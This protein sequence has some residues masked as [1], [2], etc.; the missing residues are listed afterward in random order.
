MMNEAE[1]QPLMRIAEIKIGNRFRREFGDI[2]PLVRNIGEIGMLEPISVTATGELVAG[3][4]RLRAAELLG[5]ET[6]PVTVS[7][8]KSEEIV[9]GEYAENVHRK[10][11][12]LSEAVAIAAAL[13]PLE[14]A[15]AKERQRVH[16]ETAPG[17]NTVENFSGV[18]GRAV[19][20]VAHAVGYSRPTLEKAKAVVEA[21]QAEPERY[22]KLLADMDRTGKAHGP[23]KR[24]E[25]MLQAEQI[26]AAPPPLPGG[27]YSVIVADPPWPYE[28]RADDVTH[29]AAG[30]YP[31]MPI[32]DICAL[33]VRSLAADDAILWLW[34]TN[35]HMREAFTV[36][37]AWGF[38]HKTILTWAKDRFGF[39]D[40]LRNQTEHVIMAVRGRPIVTLTNESTLLAAPVGA[41]SEKPDALF[42]RVERLC[43]ASRYLELFARQQRDGWDSW[44][45]AVAKLAEEVG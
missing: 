35:F 34:T 41:H 1:R 38:E 45:N 28:N 6:V 7:S 5:W 24:L 43:P 9:R 18:N 13:E 32:K 12:T 10:D 3:A 16:G 8:L 25:V 17:R 37:E 4:R 27:P 29:R 20:R 11:F 2:A 15:A 40:W 33:D 44:G 21:A 39:G 26:R 23:Y 42:E 31:G 30:P 36:V 19:D 14:R 22:G